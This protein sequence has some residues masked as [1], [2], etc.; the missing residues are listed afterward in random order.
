MQL[1]TPIGSFLLFVVAAVMVYRYVPAEHVPVRAWRR[2]AIVVG[3][4]LAAFTQ[5]FAFL[6]PLMLRIAALYGAIVA[7]FA[8]A[9][10]AVDRLQHPADRRRVDARPGA[11]AEPAG[12]PADEGVASP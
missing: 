7:V 4:L 3:L 1:A 6:A 12:P 10:L 5:V 9:R 11:G 2:P 8:L